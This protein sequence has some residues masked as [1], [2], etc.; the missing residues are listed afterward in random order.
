M[1]VAGL[2]KALLEPIQDVREV[3]VREYVDMIAAW[4]GY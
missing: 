4:A 2:Q 3:S 1:L